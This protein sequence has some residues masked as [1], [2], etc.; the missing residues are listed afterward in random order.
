MA[1]DAAFFILVIIWKLIFPR[2]EATS[3]SSMDEDDGVST[4]GSIAQLSKEN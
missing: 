4:I 2:I 3:H 1:Q